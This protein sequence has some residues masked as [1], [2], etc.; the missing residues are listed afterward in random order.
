M[1]EMNEDLGLSSMPWRA[2]P[3]SSFPEKV[4]ELYEQQQRNKLGTVRVK[5]YGE[6]LE[7]ADVNIE[8]LDSAKLRR[9]TPSGM[10]VAESVIA[11]V[12]TAVQDAFQMIYVESGQL[13]TQRQVVTEGPVA[14][15]DTKVSL[16]GLG[17]SQVQVELDA[18]DAAPMRRAFASGRT[19]Q[20]VSDW[21]AQRVVTAASDEL[22]KHL[23]SN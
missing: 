17:H 8:G 11:A 4:R 6:Q 5:L 20:Q 13:P 12:A 9:K 19:L 18:P 22:H 21:A 14:A 7:R 15:V 23:P 3:L 2:G 16:R 10:T 1:L